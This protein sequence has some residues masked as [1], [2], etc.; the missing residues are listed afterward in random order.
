LAPAVGRPAWNTPLMAKLPAVLLLL[1]DGLK[2]PVALGQ[3]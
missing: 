2:L 1:A 3:Y